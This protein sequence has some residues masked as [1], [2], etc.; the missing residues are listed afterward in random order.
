METATTSPISLSERAD[1]LDILRGIALLGIC[2]ANY[3]DFSLYVFQMPEVVAKM[4]TAMIDKCVAYFHFIFIDGKF[5][6]LFSLLFGIGFS[7]ILLRSR[8]KRLGLT[9]F[10]RRI[11]ILLLMGLAYVPLLWEGDILLLYALIGLCLPLFRNV[12]DKN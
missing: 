9:I 1:I 8:S 10:Y 4:P 11:I 6:G 12:S 7:I 2:L 5:Y 3:P